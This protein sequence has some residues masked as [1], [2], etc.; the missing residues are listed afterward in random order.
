MPEGNEALLGLQLGP[1]ALFVVVQTL[2]LRVL[3]K[4]VALFELAVAAVKVRVFVALSV[5]VRL[6]G[7]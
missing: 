4:V 5:T 3:E 2:K 6:S 7:G 1:E